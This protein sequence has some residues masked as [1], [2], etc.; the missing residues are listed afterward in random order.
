VGEDHGEMLAQSDAR[1][2]Q[3]HLAPSQTYFEN[4]ALT[5]VQA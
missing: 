5:S 3:T 1:N 4:I 2:E